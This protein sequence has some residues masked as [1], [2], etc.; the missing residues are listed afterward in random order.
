MFAAP[1]QI[2]E[3]V[4][5]ILTTD[6]TFDYFETLQQGFYPRGENLL[7]PDLYPWVF[8]EMGGMDNIERARSPAVWSYYY[9]V[10]IIAMTHADK[11]DPTTLVVNDGTN[12]NKGI[13]DIAADIVGI[14][15]EKKLTHFDLPN[16]VRDW[17]VQRVGQ[18]SVLNV[19]RLLLS[20]YIRGIQIDLSF[21]VR[22]RGF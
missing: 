20:P 3:K 1:N 7:I 14:L 13:Q 2:Y 9:V 22:E 21:S 16:I 10:N 4:Y 11:G 5:E 19:Q 12:E 8:I 18:P 17:T 6:S 15:W